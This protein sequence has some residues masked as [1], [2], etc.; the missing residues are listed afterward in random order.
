MG[1]PSANQLQA[2]SM[3]VAISNYVGSATLAVLAGATALFTYLSQAF[4]VGAAFYL[5]MAGGA[6]LL[7]IS[8]FAGGRG[9]QETARL[10]NS[11]RWG[12]DPKVDAFSW[13]AALAIAGLVV[14]L[15]GAAVGLAAP[16]Q[17][18]ELEERIERLEG[19]RQR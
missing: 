8:L 10:V 16:R 7:V 1:E 19:R 15:A 4:S 14:V 6:L 11:G 12:A 18:E 17:S 13:Q 5:L 2:A 3:H 9:A